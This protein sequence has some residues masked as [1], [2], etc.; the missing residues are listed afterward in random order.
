M[1][2]YIAVEGHGDIDAVGNLIARLSNDLRLDLV[3]ARP[4]RWKNLNQ[5]KGLESIAE[6]TRRQSD[7]GALLV[8]RDEDD[9]C[10]RELGP[11][12]AAVLRRLQLPFP[13]AIVLFHREYEVLFLPCLP[14]LA[15]KQLGSGVAER[16]GIVAGTSFH[17]NWEDLRGVKEWLSRQFPPGK[18]Y[19]PTLDQAPLTRLLDFEMIRKGNVPCFGTLERA[20]TFLRTTGTGVYP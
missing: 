13:V 19:K 11:R 5:E 18:S 3:W 2:G 16:P 4:I 12:S 9:G 1:K 10:P 14:I 7:V 20:L 6:Y 8:L 15:G 17:G